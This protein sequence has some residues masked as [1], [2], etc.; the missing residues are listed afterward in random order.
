MSQSKRI[1]WSENPKLAISESVRCLMK[2][3]LVAL[4]T[5]TVYGLASRLSKKGIEQIYYTKG[6]PSDNPLI[7]HVADVSMARTCIAQETPRFRKLVKAFWPGPLTLVMPKSKQLN[8][9]VTSGLATVALRNPSHVAFLTILRTISQPLVAP[10]ANLSGRPSPTRAEHILEDLDIPL[11]IDAGASQ[12]GLESTILDI[13]VSPA[14][15]LR[16]GH[17]HLKALEQVLGETIIPFSPNSNLEQ[18]RAPGIKYKHY[19]PKKTKIILLTDRSQFLEFSSE[20]K[21]CFEI[22]PSTPNIK[23]LQARTLYHIFRKADQAG[24]EALYFLKD[25]ALEQYPDLLNRL[26][27]AAN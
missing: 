9:F 1:A 18:P 15:L 22:N 5:E 20:G 24:I 17:I 14:L 4:P 6:R 2:D 16:P 13:S 27:K 8:T 10:S 25:P 11:I 21:P 19:A 7:V 23:V 26:F 12:Y 3:Q